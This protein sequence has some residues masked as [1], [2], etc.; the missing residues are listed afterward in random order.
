MLKLFQLMMAVG[1][2]W[3]IVSRLPEPVMLADPLTTIPPPGLA[4]RLWERRRRLV[5]AE[6]TAFDLF[7]LGSQIGLVTVARLFN[8]I[9]CW[10]SSVYFDCDQRSSAECD[11]LNSSVFWHADEA[12]SDLLDAGGCASKFSQTV[13]ARGSPSVGIA[14]RNALVSPFPNVADD[15]AKA[16]SV[17]SH[18]GGDLPGVYLGALKFLPN[19]LIR[20]Q[21]SA[22]GIKARHVRKDFI[23]IKAGQS[24][25]DLVVGGVAIER[26]NKSERFVEIQIR[27]AMQIRRCIQRLF[28]S[29]QGLV[30]FPGK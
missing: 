29:A 19:R 15:V 5:T 30:L 21:Q 16:N 11:G 14:K 18:I 22:N 26:V 24:K 8:P 20:A 12:Q 28:P 4:R 27:R 10:W 25:T 23:F 7:I 13:G 6:I 1:L 9:S 17:R 2:V 3:A